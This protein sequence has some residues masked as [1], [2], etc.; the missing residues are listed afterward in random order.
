MLKGFIWYLAH[1]PHFE[2]IPET[3]TLGQRTSNTARMGMY[4]T[5]IC[6]PLDLAWSWWRQNF[7]K[8]ARVPHVVLRGY[9]GKW[10]GWAGDV[11]THIACAWFFEG[12]YG[13]ICAKTSNI[14]Y[15]GLFYT[16]DRGPSKT[17]ILDFSWSLSMVQ[18]SCQETSTS[19]FKN[20]K[21]MGHSVKWT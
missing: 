10:F 4:D 11:V 12:F 9:M 21:A 19:H 14:L 16:L 1:Y 8:R 15:L 3:L 18:R 5:F 17:M 13:C 6:G 20:L 7:N 2:N